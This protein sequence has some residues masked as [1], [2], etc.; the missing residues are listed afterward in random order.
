GVRPSIRYASWP[1]AFTSV[2]PLTTAMTAG[3]LSKT[4][5]PF[6]WIRT[7]VV[8]RSTPIMTTKLP[9]K[10]VATAA[11]SAAPPGGVTMAHG[12]ERGGN[13][14]AADAGRRRARRRVEPHRGAHARAAAR[15]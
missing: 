2:V 10:P 6:T 9:G 14:A 7:L 8:P 3:S 12:A 5:L 13:G 15:R 1:T 11:F 4:P